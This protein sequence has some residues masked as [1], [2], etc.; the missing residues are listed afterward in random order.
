MYHPQHPKDLKS[1][2]TKIFC[3]IISQ[4]QFH[5]VL[6]YVQFTFFLVSIKSFFNAKQT[7]ARNIIFTPLEICGDDSFL[8]KNSS[9]PSN[10]PHFIRFKYLI[11]A[12]SLFV[13]L[14][15]GVTYVHISIPQ[16][17]RHFIPCVVNFSHNIYMIFNLRSSPHN[18]WY[19]NMVRA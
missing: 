15:W 12:C 5:F 2:Y 10:S 19:E 13:L 16:L 8:P 4:I 6:R 7:K 3:L 11:I 17:L 14:L 18:L 9:N 1:H